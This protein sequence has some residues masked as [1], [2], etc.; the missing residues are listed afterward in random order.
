MVRV[1]GGKGRTCA[2]TSS[3]TFDLANGG[4]GGSSGGVGEGAKDHFLGNSRSGL[5][6]G[7][8]G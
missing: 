7:E 4:S 3:P 8:R 5:V 1:L 2:P 6:V